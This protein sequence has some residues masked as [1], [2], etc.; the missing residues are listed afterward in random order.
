VYDATVDAD[1]TVRFELLRSARA[2][3]EPVARTGG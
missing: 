1:G 3:A 2:I